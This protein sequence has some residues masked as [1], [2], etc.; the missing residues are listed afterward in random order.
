VIIYQNWNDVQYI[1]IESVC[2][3]E[4]TNLVSA[5]LIDKLGELVVE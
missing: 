3:I 5:L 2:N 4:G 1:M